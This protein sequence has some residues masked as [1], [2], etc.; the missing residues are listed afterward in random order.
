MNA[1][2]EK[3][4]QILAEAAAKATPAERAA[5]LDAACQGDADL[6][7]QVEVLLAAHERAGDFLEKTVELP[8]SDFVIERTGTMIG[9]YKLLERIGEGGFGIVFM[10]EQQEPVQRKV[11]LK[12][13]K[14]GMDTRE[15]IARFEAER[16]VLALMDHPNIARVL[17]AGATETGRPYFVMELVRG[18][19]ITDYCDQEQISTA[20]R[21]QLFVKVCHAVQHAHQKGII[22]RDLKPT[23]ILVTVID[24]EPVPKII[25]FGVAKALGQRLTEK[26]LFTAFQQMIGTPAYMS[27]EQAALSGVDVD[28]RSDI[29]SLGVLL[30]ELLTSETPFDKETLH[31]AALD[32]IRRLIREAEPAKPSTRLRTLGDKLTEVAKH[33]Q[34]EPVA[35]TRLV[36][37][38]LDWIV[39]KALEKDRARRY[40]TANALAEDVQRHLDHEP[41]QARHPGAAYRAGK[42][43]QRHRLGAAMAAVVSAALGLGLVA[44]LIGFV[45][46][47]Q[48]R[49]RAEQLARQESQQR[50]RAEA[51]AEEARTEKELA[52]ANLQM[53]QISL[54]Q[55]HLD[56]GQIGPAL[57]L[58]EAQRPSLDMQDSRSIEWR[59]LWWRAHQGHRFTLRGHEGAVYAIACL[60]SG[61]LAASGGADGAVKL[62]DMSTGQE[63][64]T[65]VRNQA[66]IWSLAF[67]PDGKTLAWGDGAGT[68]TLWDLSHG[69]QRTTIPAHT[70]R[71]CALA[72]SPDSSLIASCSGNSSA[73]LWRADTGESAGPTLEYG[74]R[75]PNSEPEINAIA[76]SPDGQTLACAEYGSVALWDLKTHQPRV[77]L[78]RHRFRITSL[79]FSPD[80]KTLVSGGNNP[81]VKLWDVPTAEQKNEFQ[82]NITDSVCMA[83]SPDGR[84]VATG[85][86]SG[87]IEVRELASGH[88]HFYGHVGRVFSLAFSPDGKALASAGEDGTVKVWDLTRDQDLPPL[89]AGLILIWSVAFSPDGETLA[90][91]GDRDSALWHVRSRQ[92]LL[93]LPTLGGSD[94]A[95]SPDGKTLAGTGWVWDVES[96]RQVGER[97]KSSLCFLSAAFS[98]DGE[99]LI[100]GSKTGNEAVTLW[101]WKT[102]QKRATLCGHTAWV[103]SLAVSPDGRTL[104]SGSFHNGM[105]EVILWDLP[106]GHRRRTLEHGWSCVAFSPDGKTLASGAKSGG[107]ALWDPATGQLVRE[108]VGHVKGD[109]SFAF[110]PD[111]KT[112]VACNLQGGVTLW[113]VKKGLE[114]AI[115]TKRRHRVSSV[116]F[117]P[118]GQTLATGGDDGSVEI[119]R[120]ATEA[121]VRAQSVAADRAKTRIGGLPADSTEPPPK[122]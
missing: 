9:R 95:F 60:P 14:A 121:E 15:V 117:S 1:D 26:T 105:G 106:S 6:R 16:Q 33:R 92:L 109:S 44:S 81:T 111:G 41:V 37:G 59:H 49:D 98:R 69:R 22:H 90:S 82:P 87:T 104:A 13:I 65:L 67:A 8:P 100:L 61:S 107:I 45:E 118:D 31:K 2:H 89:E 79:A 113:D 4:K 119:W 70:N 114:R 103:W 120:T 27:P 84:A 115:L 94:V 5:Y 54:I 64:A 50:H 38:D 85:G 116:A 77:R 72:F 83:L 55:Q 76:F 28:T 101:D 68:I 96:R 24:G 57:A 39:M 42:F 7:Q 93:K 74:N 17:D 97:L 30:Y 99:T 48:E 34:T 53:A 3:L 29:Y 75:E 66:G 102:G 35:L 20:E 58:L 43:I 108:L 86:A 80:G 63:R 73:K 91:S 71:V 122:K 56:N 10:A 46:A 40:D 62:W 88:T 25:D 21:L 18:I 32:E 19:P 110:A 36:H 23:N 112:L 51:S 52:D 11:A 47:K 12:I 78:H